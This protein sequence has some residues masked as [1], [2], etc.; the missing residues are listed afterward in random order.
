MGVTKLGDLLEIRHDREFK[1]LSKKVIA[2][3]GFNTLYQFLSS[4][5][6]QDGTPL[7]DRE[8]NITSHLSGLFFRNI[9][10]L[11]HGI[12]LVY[13]FDGKPSELKAATVKKR[14]EA[15][16]KAEKQYKEALLEGDLEKAYSYSQRTSRLTKEILEE[17]E[18]LLG[19]LGIPV[20]HAPSEGEAQAAFLARNG[21]VDFTGSQDYDALLFNAPVLL[22]NLALSG[23]RKKP[24]KNVYETVKPELISLDENL[25]NL[26]ITREEFIDIAILVGT[27]FNPKGIH[28][29]G[30]KTAYKL[31]KEY[32]T[33]EKAIKAKDLPADFDVEAIREIFLHPNV[34]EIKELRFQKIQEDKIIEFLVERKG[35]GIDR[36]QNALERA[37][38]GWKRVHEQA[39]LDDFF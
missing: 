37:L 7:R 16:E 33:A 5:R 34:K 6:Q 12:Q 24:G 23:K 8:G 32:G 21:L 19:Y 29:V 2:L 9:R 20:I 15:R 1:E 4:I 26:G 10:L 38:K 25:K 36:I 3:D 27:D 39:S 14:V 18:E 13:V 11:E 22:R 30:P 28:G 17:S 35:F 31:I